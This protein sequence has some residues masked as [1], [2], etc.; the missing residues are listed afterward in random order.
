MFYLSTFF[1]VCV[2]PPHD[3]R[4]T[5]E[6]L[7]VPWDL[8]VLVE[9]LGGLKQNRTNFFWTIR[10]LSYPFAALAVLGFELTLDEG[11]IFVVKVTT[12]L[13]RTRAPVLV[14]GESLNVE[15]LESL[16][17]TDCRRTIFVLSFLRGRT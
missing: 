15:D 1:V 7:W 13:R 12:L 3:L 10:G 11:Q 8:V 2:D 9:N 5:A 6:V 4:C 14:D 16:K 17:S